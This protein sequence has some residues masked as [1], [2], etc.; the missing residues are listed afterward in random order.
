MEGIIPRGAKP[1]Q[2]CRALL[3]EMLRQEA[4]FLAHPNLMDYF[5]YA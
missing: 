3:V 2:G 4:S 1:D 5:I